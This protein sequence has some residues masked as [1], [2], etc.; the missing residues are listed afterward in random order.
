M[1]RHRNGLYQFRLPLLAAAVLFVTGVWRVAAQVQQA[2]VT[3]EDVAAL[4]LNHY[5]TPDRKYHS[6][7]FEWTFTPTEFVLAKGAGAIPADL[8]TRLLPP[9]MTADEIR[10]TW[11]LAQAKGET[12]PR[13]V[14]SG[15]KAGG[16]EIKKDLYHL[17][18]DVGELY[19]DGLATEMRR[20]LA[21][22]QI[23]S[24]CKRSNE[25]VSVNLR[26][27]EWAADTDDNLIA[28]SF[29]V[30]PRKGIIK[31]SEMV[32]VYLRDIFGNPFR[33]VTIDPDWLTW[34]DGTIPKLAHTIYEDHRFDILPIL[35]D[36]LQEAGCTNEDIIQHCHSS[37]PHVRGCWV[38]DLLLGKK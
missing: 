11:K 30:F 37:G 28:N 17:A 36:A 10:G 9:G 5:F 26:P 22:K 33:T 8:M 29:R 19:A 16:R 38:V 21:W 15:I 23:H 24:I 32:L 4:S 35:A 2:P 14:L 1:E 27:A 18:V 20:D 6:V 12:G 13:L 7:D 25:A 3:E 34:R 31:N